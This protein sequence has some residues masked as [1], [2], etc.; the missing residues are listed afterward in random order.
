MLYSFS[1][2]HIWGSEKGSP[3]KGKLKTD[4]WVLSILM[5]IFICSLNPVVSTVG[6]ACP[7]IDIFRVLMWLCIA[8]AVCI[9]ALF[10][11]KVIRNKEIDFYPILCIAIVI[12]L[13]IYNVKA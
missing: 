12:F 9:A 13:A 1:D 8:A 6:S 4:N 7:G 5:I 2:K 10:T 3:K 11:A